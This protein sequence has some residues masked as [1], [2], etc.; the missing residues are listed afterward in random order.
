MCFFEKPTGGTFAAHWWVFCRPAIDK[1]RG[2]KK[3]SKNS[4][5]SK[6]EI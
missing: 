1:A 4:E 3:K 2:G 5:K 6:T